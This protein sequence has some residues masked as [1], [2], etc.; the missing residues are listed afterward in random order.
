MADDAFDGVVPG[1]AFVEDGEVRVDE[2]H[3]AQIV[4]EQMAE[5]ATRFAEH[6]FLKQGI[7]LGVK[8]FVGRGEFD[9]SEVQPL[10]GEV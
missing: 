4:L 7:K 6:G 8:F 5:E 2:V 3:H 10:A 1:D 9:L